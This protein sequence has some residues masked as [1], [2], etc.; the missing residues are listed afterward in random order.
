MHLT[1]LGLLVVCSAGCTGTLFGRAGPGR[2]PIELTNTPT[3]ADGYVY[4]EDR[5]YFGPSRN[6]LVMAG[7]VGPTEI[8]GTGIASESGF[9]ADVFGEY[10][11]NADSYGFG[12]RSGIVLLTGEDVRYFGIPIMLQGAI[13]AKGISLHAGL[14]YVVNGGINVPGGVEEASDANAWR[15]NAGVRWTLPIFSDRFTLIAEGLYLTSEETTFQGQKTNF[16]ATSWQF[17]HLIAF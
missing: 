5:Q 15:A 6:G 14:G 10:M 11:F 3:R 16:E 12:L 7:L 4:E 2:T 17:G 9:A 8:S 13:G 1:T